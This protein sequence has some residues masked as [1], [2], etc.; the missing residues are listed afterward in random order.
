MT[1]AAQVTPWDDPAASLNKGCFAPGLGAGVGRVAAIGSDATG[2]SNLLTTDDGGATWVDR[3]APLGAASFILGIAYGA[4]I[5]LFVAVGG[6]GG[7]NPA[8]SLSADAI[9]WGAPFNPF[10]VAFP[11]DVAANTAGDAFVVADGAAAIWTTADGTTWFSQATA[12]PPGGSGTMVRYIDALATW[13]VCVTGNIGALLFAPAADLTFWDTISTP[14][15]GGGLVDIGYHGSSAKLFIGGGTSLGQT[16]VASSADAGAT[17]A[18]ETT[19][20]DITGVVAMFAD[21]GTFFV[22][23]GTAAVGGFVLAQTTGAGAWGTD[24]T[25]M[26]AGAAYGILDVPDLGGAFLFGQTP[27][28]VIVAFGLPTGY[29]PVP[30]PAVGYTRVYGIQIALSDDGVEQVSALV[31]SPDGFTA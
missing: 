16:F 2:A 6:D 19:P 4:A 10:G 15:D 7:G 22:A 14:A 3:G 30:P 29:T 28:G 9:T 8:V 21:T 17:W 31:L 1:W 5:G 13:Y 24:A 23:I 18:L 27:A 25:P 11:Y 20:Y 26:D 12:L